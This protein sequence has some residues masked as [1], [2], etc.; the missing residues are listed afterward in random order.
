MQHNKFIKI[1]LLV[2]PLAFL[3]GC[4]AVD[5]IKEKLGG[6]TTEA[7]ATK[8]AEAKEGGAA[9]QM[10]GEV[11]ATMSGKAV[12]TVSGLKQQMNQLMEENPQLKSVLPFMPDVEYNVFKSMVSQEVVNRYV[13]ENKIKDKEE[14]RKDKERAEKALENALNYKYFALANPVKI[15]ETE[16]KNFYETYKNSIPEL[17]ISRGGVQATGVAFDSEA[18]AKGFF[19][20]VKGG[21]AD[22][23][24]AA[25]EAGMGDKVR[26]FKLVNAQSVGIDPVLRNKIVSTTKFPSV[27]MLKAGEQHWV[28]AVTAKEEAKYR[29]FEQVKGDIERE[30]EKQKRMEVFEQQINKLKTEYKVTENDSYFKKQAAQQQQQ[31]PGQ[32]MPE[33][34]MEEESE[35]MAVSKGKQ[36]APA[37]AQAQVAA[38]TTDAKAVAEK[39]PATSSS[40]VAKARSAKKAAAK[41]A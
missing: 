20:K 1:A 7:G 33:Q 16:V 5:W 12:V 4:A 40:T 3:P 31:K 37:E 34:Q 22:F 39:K 13:V 38:A 27:E 24:K 26:D 6:G 28:V 17:M 41:V 23:A 10:S 2:T 15:T 9:E 21:K 32:M 36:A 25:K 30:V 8:P 29:P 18:K 19:E 14:Y 35:D 11:L